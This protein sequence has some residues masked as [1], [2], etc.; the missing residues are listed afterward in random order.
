MNA[1]RPLSFAQ[2]QADECQLNPDAVNLYH[3][4]IYKV[5]SNFTKEEAIKILSDERNNH[6]FQDKTA[7]TGKLCDV[8]VDPKKFFEAMIKLRKCEKMRGNEWK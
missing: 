4:S 6:F 3:Y 2:L 8:Y 1:I 7:S 5:R